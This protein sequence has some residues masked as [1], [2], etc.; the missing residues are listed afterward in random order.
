MRWVANYLEALADP[1]HDEHENMVAWRGP[2]DPEASSLKRI[3]ASLHKAYYR[4][5]ALKKSA[6]ED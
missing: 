6:P 5:P 1:Q 3:N 4:P 2:F